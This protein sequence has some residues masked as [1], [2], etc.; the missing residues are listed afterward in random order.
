MVEPRQVLAVA[1][2]KGGVGKTTTVINLG[3]YLG[4]LG[5]SVL[6]VDRDPQASAT[7]SVTPRGKIATTL[8]E[9]LLENQAPQD[10]I[11]LTTTPNLELLPA[12]PDLA[13]SEIELLDALDRERA[14]RVA[15]D[16]VDK[17]YDYILVDCPP[18]LVLLTVNALVASDAVVVP[19]QCEYL[20]LEGVARLLDTISR[21][22][23]NLNPVLRIFGLL[24]T[25]YDRRTS[26]SEQVAAEVR[27]HYPELTFDTVISRNV[28]LGEAPSFGQPILAYDPVSLGAQAYASLA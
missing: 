4:A 28:R 14:L 22:R 2:Q 24:M 3:A 12:S 21:I 26:L 19:V 20:A 9:V 7:R 17:H 5:H 25:M 15:L 1:N 18:S 10:A 11:V 6:L 27:R 13:G 23:S 16:R 8:Y